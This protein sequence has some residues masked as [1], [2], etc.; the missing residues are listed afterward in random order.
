MAVDLRVSPK[1]LRSRLEDVLSLGKRTPRDRGSRVLP[2][3]K[4][5]AGRV[6]QRHSPS[7]SGDPIGGNGPISAGLFGALK[8]KTT[9]KSCAPRSVRVANSVD[10]AKGTR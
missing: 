6:L 8:G 4:W 7:S 5:V 9:L 3:L 10:N 1:P 2:G